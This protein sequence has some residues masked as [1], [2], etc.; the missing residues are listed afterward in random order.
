[1]VVGEH[2]ELSAIFS[3]V[4]SAL[5]AGSVNIAMLFVM[6]VIQGVGLGMLLA[7]VPL[8]LTEVAPAKHRGFLTGSTQFSTGIGYIAYV[9][10]SP[11]SRSSADKL[12][13]GAHGGHLDATTP[14]ILPSAGDF[15]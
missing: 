9:S 3:L 12:F 11:P 2:W 5:V 10:H 14:Q 7:L 8:Y 15:P 1:L 13:P 6:R 4:G